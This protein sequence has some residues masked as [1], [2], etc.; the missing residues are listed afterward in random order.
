VP[1]EIV[2]AL[3]REVQAVIA[4]PDFKTKLKP[5]GFE[6]LPL[7][8]SQLASYM[9]SELAK[10]GKLAKQAGLEPQ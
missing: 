4:V 3:N 9:S 8:A 1:R 5:L 10:W 6:T 2:E 7:N